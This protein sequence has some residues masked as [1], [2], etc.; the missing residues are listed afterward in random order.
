MR[1]RA[2]SNTGDYTFGQGAANFLVDSPQAVGQ[3]VRTRL[4]LMQGEWFLDVREGTPYA[5]QILGE[6]KQ[7]T[8]DQ[9]IRKQI[10]GTEGVVNIVTYSS[11]VEGR[12]LHVEA[13]INTIY[14][15]T[16]IQQVI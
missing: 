10:L 11:F 1:Y 2:L 7:A 8:Y 13:L 4:L 14:G 5:T 16:T 3:A 12:N 9:A 6:H 15:Q